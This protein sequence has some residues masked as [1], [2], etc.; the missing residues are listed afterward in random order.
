MGAEFSESQWT[1]MKEEMNYMQDS[2]QL[3]TLIYHLYFHSDINE[4]IIQIIPE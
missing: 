1:G 4:E 3:F 2:L